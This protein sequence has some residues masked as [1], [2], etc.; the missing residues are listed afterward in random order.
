MNL[1][2][3]D[4]SPRILRPKTASADSRRRYGSGVQGAN[5]SFVGFS[6]GGEGKGEGQLHGLAEGGTP[7][8]VSAPSIFLQPAG[9]LPGIPEYRG[10]DPR[11]KEN[12]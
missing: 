1:V 6:P 7:N 10:R 2:A 11:E 3:A 8:L 5:N 9:P 12:H 4:V